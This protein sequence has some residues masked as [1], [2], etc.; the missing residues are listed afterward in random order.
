MKWGGQKKTLPHNYITQAIA[1]KTIFTIVNFDK[2]QLWINIK[3]ND[4]TYIMRIASISKI[5]LLVKN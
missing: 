1:I 2:V 4:D 3:N 5:L